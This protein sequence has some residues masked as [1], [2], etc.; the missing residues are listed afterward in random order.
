MSVNWMFIV[1]SVLQEVPHWYLPQPRY[2]SNII[3]SFSPTV[4]TTSPPSPAPSNS[5]MP[6]STPSTLAPTTSPAPSLP[7]AKEC[8]LIDAVTPGAFC[9][10][11]RGYGGGKG[12]TT[13]Y[14]MKSDE[15][16]GAVSFEIDGLPE[17]KRCGDAWLWFNACVDSYGCERVQNSATFTYGKPNRR[18][19]YK[20]AKNTVP[21]YWQFRVWGN[22]VNGNFYWNCPT[23]DAAYGMKD[24]SDA[25]WKADLFQEVNDYC[26]SDSPSVSMVPTAS[27]APS[28]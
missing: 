28:E 22:G 17:W 18:V 12:Y 7:Q 9:Y 5:A 6:S 8:A 16:C 11:G 1:V 19:S 23:K 20:K 15:F 13:C 27:P 26:L 3:L 10:D 25:V 2:C 21:A 24:F 14:A 4:P